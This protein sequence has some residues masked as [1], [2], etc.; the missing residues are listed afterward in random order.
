MC[1]GRLILTAELAGQFSVVSGRYLLSFDMT[2]TT[3]FG[4]LRN[5]SELAHDAPGQPVRIY[6]PT[7]LPS[8]PGPRHEIRGSKGE[9]GALDGIQAHGHTVGAL[10]GRRRRSAAGPSTG[11]FSKTRCCRHGGTRVYTTLHGGLRK[12]VDRKAETPP[13]MANRILAEGLSAIQ[14]RRRSGTL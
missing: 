11:K 13:I 1:P 12:L 14:F 7:S 9:Q 3:G 6:S 4:P 2:S 10:I 8:F 5:D